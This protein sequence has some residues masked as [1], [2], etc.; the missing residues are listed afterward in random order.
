M[1]RVPNDLRKPEIRQEYLANHLKWFLEN[2]DNAIEVFKK[3]VKEKYG[4]HAC[5]S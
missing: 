1:E 5:K 3:S 4:E 2:H